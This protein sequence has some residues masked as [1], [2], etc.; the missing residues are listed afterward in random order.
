MIHFSTTLYEFENSIII[1]KMVTS[2]APIFIGI[3]NSISS[4]MAPPSISASEVEMEANMAE[5]SRNL[6]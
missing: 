6:E 5:V 2:S 1:T 4:A 3:P